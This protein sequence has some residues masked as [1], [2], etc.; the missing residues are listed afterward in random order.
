ML[1]GMFT[2]R[3]VGGT[4]TTVVASVVFTV[5]GAVA[6][7]GLAYVL[8]TSDGPITSWSGVILAEL[9]LVCWTAFAYRLGRVGVF[10]SLAG[11][12][13]RS[14]WRTQ[15]LAWPDI[16]RF[17]TQPV[18]RGGS[19]T[20]MLRLHAVWILLKNGSELR[21]SLMYRDRA[22]LRTVSGSG[23]ARFM[24]NIAGERAS[25]VVSERRCQQALRDLRAAQ[26]IAGQ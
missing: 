4:P 13:N 25:L 21:T 24:D 26:D 17:E 22:A 15:T 9:F 12:R 5:A 10:V 2:W 18:S 8:I 7:L 14:M 23:L 19:A 20:R 3:R 1:W 16:R 6:T 11:V